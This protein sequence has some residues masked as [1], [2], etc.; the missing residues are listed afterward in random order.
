MGGVV[1]DVTDNV[2]LTNEDEVREQGQS[3]AEQAAARAQRDARAKRERARRAAA[4]LRQEQKIAA[5]RA[6]KQ[7]AAEQTAEADQRR[8]ADAVARG[9][10][11]GLLT[12]A[13]KNNASLGDLLGTLG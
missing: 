4:K 13:A 2:G 5:E 12:F 7:R 3:A 6:R 8:D 9:G 10:K 11:M 1:T